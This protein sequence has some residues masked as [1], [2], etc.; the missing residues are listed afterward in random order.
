MDQAPGHDLE[1]DARDTGRDFGPGSMRF[2]VRRT[3]RSIF[4]RKLLEIQ[5]IITIIIITG[6]TQNVWESVASICMNYVSLNSLPQEWSNGFSSKQIL[7]E[8]QSFYCNFCRSGGRPDSEL[9]NLISWH[10]FKTIS[11]PLLGIPVLYSGNV[12][13]F[14]EFYNDTFEST[15]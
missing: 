14:L 5:K 9:S 6:T 12:H 10:N 1:S 15:I 4:S 7:S 8:T 2:V 13:G 3:G 11:K